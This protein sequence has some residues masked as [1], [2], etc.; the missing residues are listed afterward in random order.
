MKKIKVLLL[1]AFC[2]FLLPSVY[3]GEAYVDSINIDAEIKTDGS[4]VVKETIVWDIVE[5][6]NGVYRDILTYNE[7]NPTNSASDIVVNSVVVN[8]KEFSYSYNTL[9]NGANGKYNVNELGNGKQIKIF[10][11]SSDEYKETVITY[12]LKNVV[13]EYNDTAELYWNFIGNGWEYGIDDV[14]IKIKLPCDS[15]DL[16]VFAHGPLHGYST[17]TAK[18]EV[19]ISVSNLRSG[20]EV[21]VR[22]L[23]DTSLVN[24]NKK[25]S[26]DKL[27][28]I[29][30]KEAKL[31]IEANRKRQIAKYAFFI[32][33]TVVIIAVLIP[34]MVYFNA[35][36]KAY[37]A[38]FNGKYY[39]ELPEDYGP[40]VMNKVLNGAMGSVSSYDMLATLLDLVRRKYI[41]IESIYKSGKK[42]PTDYNL[43]L[44]KTDL[45]DLNDLEKHFIQELIFVDTTEI[46]LKELGKKN[47]KSMKAKSKAVEAYKKWEELIKKEA[48]NK[49]L[50]IDTKGKNT[51]GILLCVLAIILCLAVAIF[52]FVGFYDDIISVGMVSLMITFYSSIFIGFKITDLGLRTQKGVE[53]KAMWKAF[54]KFLQ[55]FSKLDEHEYKSIVIWEHFLVYATALGISREV[56]KQLKIVFPTEFEE[57]SS[58]FSTYITMGILSDSSTFSSFESSFSSATATA[59]SAPSSSSGSGGGFSGGAGG[60]RWRR[61]WRRIL[62]TKHIKTQQVN[63]C[64][65]FLALLLKKTDKMGII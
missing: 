41:Q 60:G 46:A 25:V 13:V 42:K 54:K 62:V 30:E 20:E 29:L 15:E 35:K 11:P 40:A 59:F 44:I 63:S 16:G 12:T 32:S 1:I 7:A 14:N 56:I 50:I 64:G 52:G 48:E 28:S 10:T 55:D 4:M 53:H 22:L 31:A 34:I 61:R 45:E 27:D 17:I 33:I 26:V 65:F 23:F 43:K 57:N 39:R 47:S 24:T 21:D 51:K 2:I 37:K 5:D 38:T 6:L 36:K 3:A 19:L 8:G 18:D 49:D 9:F 58:M